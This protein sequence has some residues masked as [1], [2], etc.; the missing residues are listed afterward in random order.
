MIIVL[1]GKFLFFDANVTMK[2]RNY[3]SQKIEDKKDS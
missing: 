2:I 1:L 3:T